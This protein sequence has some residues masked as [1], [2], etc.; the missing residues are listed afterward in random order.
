M[1]YYAKN[2]DNRLSIYVSVDA[3]V[4]KHIKLQP[5]IASYVYAVCINWIKLEINKTFRLNYVYSRM[6]NKKKMTI[7]HN[8]LASIGNN[9]P[10]PTS[11]QHD[12]LIFRT[13][14]TFPFEAPKCSCYWFLKKL[15]IWLSSQF[16]IL[17]FITAWIL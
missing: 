8:L 1:F 14:Q 10:Q 3:A 12:T 13:K 2:V 15:F 16:L 4:G 17:K 6:K 9:N 11:P 5:L 7:I